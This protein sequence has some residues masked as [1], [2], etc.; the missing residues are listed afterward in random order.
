[1][2]PKRN[3]EKY[4]DPERGRGPGGHWL[5]HWLMAMGATTLALI[6]N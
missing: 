4:L 1:M 6:S 3:E 5:I 2:N